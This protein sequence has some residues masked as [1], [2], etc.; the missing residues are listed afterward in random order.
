MLI[1]PLFP[2]TVKLQYKSF[3]NFIISIYSFQIFSTGSK[4]Q[5]TGLGT[6]QRLT[7]SEKHELSHM[8]KQAATYKDMLSGYYVDKLSIMKAAWDILLVFVSFYFFP[9]LILSRTSYISQIH[10]IICQFSPTSVALQKI[11]LGILKIDSSFLYVHTQLSKY[12][13][14]ISLI[15]FVHSLH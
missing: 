2:Q 13:Q 15:V 5:K 3:T 6:P 7:V 4:Q 9:L 11:D 14:S 10:S 1:F 8:T 12:Y